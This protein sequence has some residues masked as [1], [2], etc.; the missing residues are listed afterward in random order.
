MLSQFW[1]VIDSLISLICLLIDIG[2]VSV[3]RSPTQQGPH[4]LASTRRLGVF[5]AC[6]CVMSWQS[7]HCPSCTVCTVVCMLSGLRIVEFKYSKISLTV[8]L[9]I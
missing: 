6:G 7:C 3:E 9:K 1:T 5:M 8:I 2:R 4:L